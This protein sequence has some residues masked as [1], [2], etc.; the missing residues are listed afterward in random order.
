METDIVRYHEVKLTNGT[1]HRT[2]LDC[3]YLKPHAVPRIFPNL[4]AY[5]SSDKKPRKPPKD[6]VSATSFSIPSNS[7]ISISSSCTNDATS[8]AC[9]SG[10]S[11]NLEQVQHYDH[12]MLSQDLNRE[13]VNW[14]EWF[15]NDIKYQGEEQILLAHIGTSG[16][17]D[18]YMKVKKSDLSVKVGIQYTSFLII[19]CYWT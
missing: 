1:I 12:T 3:P 9:E 18:K 2:K 6:R 19:Y 14:P 5:L 13:K 7:D 15:W 17:P 8:V 11:H 10:I 4:P 16:L